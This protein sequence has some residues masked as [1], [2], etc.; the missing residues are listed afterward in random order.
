MSAVFVRIAIA[1]APVVKLGVESSKLVI[2]GY[3]LP[4]VLSHH[5]IYDALSTT[6]HM[7]YAKYLSC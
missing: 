2:S 5:S 3:M 7:I 4:S 1:R 6:C